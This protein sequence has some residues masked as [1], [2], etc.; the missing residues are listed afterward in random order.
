MK[1][2]LLYVMVPLVLVMSWQGPVSAQTYKSE[3]RKGN[4]AFMEKG[5]YDSA[6]KHYRHALAADTAYVP[7][8]HNM[9]Y[10]LHSD[11]RDSTKNAVKDTLALQYLDNL[12]KIAAGTEYEFSSYFNRGVIC[13]DMRDWQGAVDAFKKCLILNPGDMKSLENYVF[14]KKHLEKNQQQQ[15]Q[16]QQ[17]QQQEQQ[18]DQQQQEQQQEQE[19]QDQQGSQGQQQQDQQ[20]PDDD[21]KGDRKDDQKGDQKGDQ[22][23][24]RKDDHKGDQKDDQK[25]DQ[26]GDGSD[27]QS[28]KDGD[29]DD[30]ESNPEQGGN[31][32]DKSKIS[33]QNAQQIL[34]AMQDKEKATQAKVNKKKA[35]AMKSGTKQRQKNW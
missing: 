21:Q 31:Q 19:Q 12:A 22:K 5:N 9:A 11:R 8:M 20:Q 35:E 4:K 33:Q 1:K 16:Q 25:D 15:Q 29:K 10:V 6:I 23:D 34:Q 2:I 7:A 3:T 32:A 26:K 13:I 17:E 18:Q 28:D 14:A 27:G 24:D 30:S